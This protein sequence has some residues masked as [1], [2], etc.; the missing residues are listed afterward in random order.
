MVIIAKPNK[1]D[2]IGKRFGKLVVI[3]FSHTNKNYRSYWECKCDCGN[4][5]II[6]RHSLISG[7]S[8]SCGCEIKNNSITH[9]M[10]YSRIYNIWKCMNQRCYNPN[11]TYYYNY[12]GRGIVICNEWHN[13]EKFYNWAINNG[14]YEHIKQFDEQN[15]TVERINVN[16]NYEPNNC[17]WATR[18][19]QANNKRYNKNQ[20][21][22]HYYE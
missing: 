12:G 6:S 11:Y 9:N 22:V 7:R 4:I 13:F 5:K 10:S 3:K 15:T 17:K 1:E 16:G 19:E 18:K 21:G 20:Y 2:L 14:Y 8:K